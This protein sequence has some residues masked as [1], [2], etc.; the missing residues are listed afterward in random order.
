MGVE[1]KKLFIDYDKCL[2]CSECTV[3]CSYIMHPENNGITS[4][5]EE[6]AFLFACRRCEANPCINVC[7]NEALK[8][9]DGVVKRA[10]FLCISCKSCSLACPFGTILPEI[11]PYLT[12]RCD[13]CLERLKE[14]EIPECVKSCKYDAIKFVEKDEIKEE[15]NIYEFDN[16]IVKVFNWLALYGIKK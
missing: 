6:I 3:K 11:I 12:S 5:R 8:K 4:L 16:I 14:N 9:E 15:E 10:N 2:K 7:P 1:M 13:R